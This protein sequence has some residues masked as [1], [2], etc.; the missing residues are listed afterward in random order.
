M[1][2]FL[3]VFFLVFTFFA[4]TMMIAFAQEGIEQGQAGQNLGECQFFKNETLNFEAIRTLS[5]ATEKAADILECLNTISKIK[6]GDDDSWYNEWIGTADHVYQF[7]QNSEKSGHLVSAYESYLRAW[8]YY[9]TADFFIH[10]NPDDSRVLYAGRRSK[11]CFLKA[12]PGLGYSVE[13]VRI[14]YEGTTLPGYF[15]HSLKVKGK[16]PVLMVHSGFDGTKEEIVLYPGLGAADRGYDVLAFDGPGQGE[17]VREQ[18]LYFRP[19]WEKVVAPVVDYLVK[20]KDVDP[21]KIAYMG[22]SLG[23]L[24]APRA[25]AYEHR[26]KVLITN[27]GVCSFYQAIAESFDTA[28]PHFIELAFTDPQKFNEIMSKVM[29]ESTEVR[30]L[31]NNGNMSFGTKDPAGFIRRLED[32]DLVDAGKIKATTLVIDVENEQFFKGQAQELYDR[33]TASKTMMVFVKA[34]GMQDHCQ[35]GAELAGRGPILDWLDEVINK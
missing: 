19:D 26:I 16:A 28:S 12:L 31:I 7:A 9:R 23:G 14:P 5:H 30:W 25:A 3:W 21:N 35:V 34:D 17:V 29:K 10:Q 1:K 8:N 24:L 18:K 22:I 33:I 4:S 20:R 6:A 32:F 11:E 2:K 13:V 27:G 15:I